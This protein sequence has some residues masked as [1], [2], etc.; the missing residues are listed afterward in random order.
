MSI[1]FTSVE[2]INTFFEK[3]SSGYASQKKIA[4]ELGNKIFS[5]KKSYTKLIFKEAQF[6]TYLA[7]PDL[8]FKMCSEIMWKFAKK[9][10]DNDNN[11][12]NDDQNKFTSLF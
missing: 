1:I 7:T 5:I 11:I 10:E 9:I 4:Y 2:S 3:S 12:I 6:Y 8:E